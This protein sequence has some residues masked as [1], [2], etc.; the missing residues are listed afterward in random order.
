MDFTLTD[1]SEEDHPP[2]KVTVEEKN[3]VLFIRPEG[4]GDFCSPE[5]EGI[6][7]ILERYEGQLRLVV[8]SDINEEDSTH[9]IELED[10]KESELKNC[11]GKCVYCDIRLNP[12]CKGRRPG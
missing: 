12:L 9:I 6:P 5:G 8:W 3:G 10:A 11:G 7:V 4:Y 1:Q 2:C